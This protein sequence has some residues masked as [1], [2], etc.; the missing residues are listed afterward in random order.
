MGI[1][2]TSNPQ[3]LAYLEEVRRLK[4]A[5][6]TPTSKPSQAPGF[7]D[8]PA[9]KRVGIF[10]ENGELVLSLPGPPKKP[11]PDDCCQ[12]GC[13]PCI[14]DTY[15]DALFD[16]DVTVE[17][18]TAKYVEL[19]EQRQAGRAT[20]LQSPSISSSDAAVPL[21]YPPPDPS[22]LTVHSFSEFEI[23]TIEH[24]YK[25][26]IRLVCQP[27]GTLANGALHSNGT[28][29]PFKISPGFHVFL[30]LSI[31]GKLYTKAYTPI[32]ERHSPQH[33][34]LVIKLYEHHA[35]S[36]HIRS[37]DIGH[38]L[39]LRGPIHSG[40]DRTLYNSQYQIIMVAV[41]SGITPMY[42]Y[43]QDLAAKPRSA[44][45]PVCLLYGNRTRAHVWLDR[46]L[47]ELA[48]QSDNLIVHH[49][50]T[51]DLSSPND[52]E[53]PRHVHYHFDI[54][55]MTAQTIAPLLSEF[56][57][58]FPPSAPSL[59]PPATGMSTASRTDRTVV[60]V[61]GPKEFNRSM[62]QGFQ[63]L[64]YPEGSLHVFE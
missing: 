21:R 37:L 13:V 31:A 3:V 42:Q 2:N 9:T 59:S 47:T 60:L 39:L 19:T 15:R 63:N 33:L 43:L 16:Y 54:G 11:L 36:T 8:L 27:A 23:T 29:M 46:E 41:G 51:Q 58:A 56:Y 45:N 52:P 30:R 48:Q 7:S 40:F 12:S 49:V 4:A 28:A 50:L 44:R 22:Y 17:R 38:R 61:C 25:D 20:S 34:A 62:Q 18:L 64:G 5:A 57:Q 26:S 24:V 53:P 14:F 35:V 1:E 32:V 55:R 10:E 6:P